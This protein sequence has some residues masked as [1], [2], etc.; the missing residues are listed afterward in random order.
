MFNLTATNVYTR[1]D[2]QKANIANAFIGYGVAGSST[3][4]YVVDANNQQIPVNEN[5]DA[6]PATVAFVSVNGGSRMTVD[7][8]NLTF[9]QVVRV[10]HAG[11]KI[12]TDNPYHRGRAYN[13]GERH[14]ATA[15]IQV[16]AKE[17]PTPFYSVWGL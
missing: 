7:N 13:V 2:Q 17:S 10:L 6:S 5:I 16:G 1:K 9:E 3:A 15:L 12:V 8:L 11:G 4:Q 14:I